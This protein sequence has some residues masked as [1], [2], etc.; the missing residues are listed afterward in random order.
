MIQNIF[1]VS[2]NNVFVAASKPKTTRNKTGFISYLI[3]IIKQN[4]LENIVHRW[5]NETNIK[6]LRLISN[7]PPPL[8]LICRQNSN[9][10]SVKPI[11]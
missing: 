1:L 5:F 6:I 4:I 9:A 2:L 11:L 7:A 3:K 8:L 10:S